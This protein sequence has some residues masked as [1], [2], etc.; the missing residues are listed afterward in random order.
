MSISISIC[1]T[2]NFR[3]WKN[4]ALKH[5]D[6]CILDD[7]AS[8]WI[9]Y[10]MPPYWRPRFPLLVTH[11]FPNQNFILEWRMYMYIINHTGTSV[12]EILFTKYR[13]WSVHKRSKLGRYIGMVVCTNITL[14]YRWIVCNHAISCLECAQTYC[15]PIENMRMRLMILTTRMYNE[16]NEY[17]LNLLQVWLDNLVI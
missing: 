12:Q 16:N 9:L 1:S 5:V 8:L 17:M 14:K 7:L 6:I 2:A 13:I 11:F 10:W 4:K 3:S 15:H